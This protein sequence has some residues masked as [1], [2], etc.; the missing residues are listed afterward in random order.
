MNNLPSSSLKDHYHQPDLTARIAKALQDA[1]MDLGCGIG[2]P[3]RFLAQEFGCR[4]LGLDLVASY[5][6]AATELTRLTGLD[7]LVRFQQGDMGEMPLAN[8]AFDRV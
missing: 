1:G 5:C 2:G 8:H 3:A 6:E 7:D 4:V